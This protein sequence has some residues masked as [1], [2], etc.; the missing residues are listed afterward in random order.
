MLSAQQIEIHMPKLFAVYLG[1]TS[2][3][4]HIE[5]HDVRFVVGET[6][7]DTFDTLRAEWIGQAKGLHLDAY[8]ELD[9]VDGY[10]ITLQNEAPEQS[11]RL[12]FV[13]L[14]GYDPERF[15]ELHEV[16]FFVAETEDVAKTKAKADLLSR[17]QQKHKDDLF[18]VD[19]CLAL[20]R[21]GGLH[22]RLTPSEVR[23]PLKPDWW[24]YRV[25]G[26]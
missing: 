10:Q 7:D 22:I 15:T 20:D 13:N 26:K 3:G 12:Y 8:A 6:I 17:A 25:I 14:G 23:K 9:Y 5:Q 2:A 16:G 21:V 18:D 1:G 4:C 11:Q 24:G 19:D